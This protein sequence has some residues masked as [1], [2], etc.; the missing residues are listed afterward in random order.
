MSGN[1]PLDA[2]AWASKIRR[3]PNLTRSSALKLMHFCPLSR[4]PLLFVILAS[5]T[6]A[7]HGDNV[8]ANAERWG[9]H[10]VR[11]GITAIKGD[12]STPQHVYYVGDE[13]EVWLEFPRGSGLLE[14]GA[15]DAHVVVFARGGSVFDYRMRS[16]SGAASR[17]LWHIPN[18]DIDTLPEGQYQLGLVVTVHG[19]DATDLDD[20]YGGF[21]ALLDS[22]AIYVAATPIDTDINL[23]GEHDND[24]DGD[25]INGEEADE[26]DDDAPR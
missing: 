10:V 9:S 25:G 14:S 26:L 5:L 2:G 11:N 4:L 13:L 6:P 16:Y 8:A 21:R 1:C 7:A 22:E 12:L 23:D 20:W 3:L 17:R 15:V 18:I 24:T 19:G